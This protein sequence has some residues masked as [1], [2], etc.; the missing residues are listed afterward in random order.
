MDTNHL[1]MQMTVP[2]Y[3]NVSAAKIRD[4]F[5]FHAKFPVLGGYEAVQM[6][7]SGIVIRKKQDN[8]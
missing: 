3:H 4:Y 8:S 5:G 2:L 1:K 7:E 6:E